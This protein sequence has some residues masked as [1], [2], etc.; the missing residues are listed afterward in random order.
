MTYEVSKR[1]QVKAAGKAKAEA[2]AEAEADGTD[3]DD[4][5]SQAATATK[6]ST[7]PTISIIIPLLNEVKSTLNQVLVNGRSAANFWST[8]SEVAFCI[9]WAALR[10]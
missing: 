1:G 2:E 7:K 6:D 4:T 9:R 5:D 10:C 8:D 3:V